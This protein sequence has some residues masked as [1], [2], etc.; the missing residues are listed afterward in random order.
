MLAGAAA[1]TLAVAGVAFRSSPTMV[2]AAL[3]LVVALAVVGPDLMICLGM[4][5]GFGLA[6]YVDPIALTAGG[7]P[8]WLLGFLFAAGLMLIVFASRSLAGEPLARVQPSL[9]LYLLVVL[10]VYTFVQM[11]QSRPMEAPSIAA[12]FVAFPAAALVTF[13]WLLH[14]QTLARFQRLLPVVVALVAAWALAYCAASAG[15]CSTC[16]GWV[17]SYSARPGLLGDASRLYTWGQEALLGL[18]VLAFARALHKPSKLWTALT[19]LGVLCVLLQASRAQ[20]IALF[21]GFVVL[22]IWRLRHMSGVSKALSLLLFG[23]AL[24]AVLSSAVGEHIVTGFRDLQ[25]GT[26]NGG[27]RVELVSQFRPNWTLFG[28]GITMANLQRGFDVDLGI[29]NT[30][31]VLGWVGA[32]IQLLALATGALRG[33][34]AG[35]A[36]GVAFAAVLVMVLIARPT[37]PF[38]ETGP[39]AVAYGMTLGAVAALYVH[40]GRRARNAP[41]LLGWSR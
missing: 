7:L 20:E 40:A 25:A 13:V 37:L 11:G 32:G 28:G 33:L 41:Q 15:V 10:F 1:L 16:A 30:I 12:P 9:L 14:E 34:L 4:L 6:P 36:I 21:G 31:L 5:V 18:V 26:G 35:T 29:P 39:G 2:V 22:L 19:A 24:Y 27:Y 23:I 3:A 38:L 17:S 8:V